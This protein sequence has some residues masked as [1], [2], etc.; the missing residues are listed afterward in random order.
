MV[1]ADHASAGRQYRPARSLK[2][3]G[4]R[5]TTFHFLPLRI[6]DLSAF[7]LPAFIRLHGHSLPCLRRPFR[8]AWHPALRVPHSHPSA[9]NYLLSTWPPSLLCCQE[10]E[11]VRLM[12]AACRRALIAH[13]R[14]LPTLRGQLASL[15]TSGASGDLPQL[16]AAKHF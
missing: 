3:T 9:P 2:I 14:F 5:L 1:I 15:P 4:P 13:R 12:S 7:L 8:P 11:L 16:P 10:S 6:V